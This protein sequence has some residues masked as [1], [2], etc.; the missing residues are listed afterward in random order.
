M[1]LASWGDSKDSPRALPHDEGK[2]PILG[3]GYLENRCRFS[4]S[5]N[6]EG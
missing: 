6:L 3:V 2:E 4:L 1:V 5:G